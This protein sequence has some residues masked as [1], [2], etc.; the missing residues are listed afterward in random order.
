MILYGTHTA[1][2][3]HCFK[4]ACYAIVNSYFLLC[5]WRDN[6]VS[7]SKYNSVLSFGHRLF[8]GLQQNDSVDGLYRHESREKLATSRGTVRHRRP[9][10]DVEKL[11]RERTPFVTKRR[12]KEDWSFLVMVI[13]YRASSHDFC[14]S[15]SIENIEN[16]ALY[17][18]YSFANEWDIMNIERRT[19]I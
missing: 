1:Q 2:I 16:S 5:I 3:I 14:T 6:T 9:K 17:I 4:T 11:R 8:E 19:R 10:T 15:S 7:P 12:E 13:T 18:S